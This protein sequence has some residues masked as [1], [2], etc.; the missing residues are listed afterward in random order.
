MEMVKALGAAESDAFPAEDSHR[1]DEYVKIGVQTQ[2]GNKWQ[3][4]YSFWIRL[5]SIRYKRGGGGE[6]GA[7]KSTVNE[8]PEAKEGTG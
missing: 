6:S 8:V 7:I 2:W 1:I 3:C 4:S 5:D